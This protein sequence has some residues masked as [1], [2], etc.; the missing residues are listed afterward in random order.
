MLLEAVLGHAALPLI[1]SRLLLGEMLLLREIHTVLLRPHPLLVDE[2]L[3]ARLGEPL[4]VL[5]LEGL[6]LL[7]GVLLLDSLEGGL[8]RRL[9]LGLCKLGVAR[10]LLALL[11]FERLLSLLLLFALLAPLLLRG[12]G[13]LSLLLLQL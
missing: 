6:L 13:L 8:L 2:L 4:R 10:R 12:L 9:L 7:D 1:G 5:L 11:R 3:L